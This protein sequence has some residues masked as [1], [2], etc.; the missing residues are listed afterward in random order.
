MD[1]KI[2]HL[3]MIENV[4]ERM[5][6]NSFQLKGWT[7]TLVTLIG[8][9]SAN[10]SSKGFFLFAFIPLIAFWFVDSMYLQIERKYSELFKE[11]TAKEETDFN[12]DVSD[13]DK[14][15][16]SFCSCLWSKTEAYFYLPITAAV[17][18]LARILKVI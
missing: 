17:I 6:R 2:K 1:S 8:G 14:V 7:V 9:F 16:V 11:V 4:I 13:I 3:E 18:V 10:Q 15:R 5:A 12:M